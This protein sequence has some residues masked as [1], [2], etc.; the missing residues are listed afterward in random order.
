MRFVVSVMVGAVCCVIGVF[1]GSAVF[2][3]VSTVTLV[4]AAPVAVTIFGGL[5]YFLTTT[6]EV[7]MEDD[8][9][10][11]RSTRNGRTIVVMLGLFFGTLLGLAFVIRVI[12]GLL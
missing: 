2:R 4:V 8:K 5:I 1:F 9:P 3:G 10:L 11:P 7:N 6:R 12:I